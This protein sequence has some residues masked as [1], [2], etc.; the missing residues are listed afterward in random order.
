MPAWRADE[1]DGVVTRLGEY[2][3]CSVEP[4]HNTHTVMPWAE[5]KQHQQ[6][7]NDMQAQAMQNLPPHVR[8]QMM[9]SITAAQQQMQSMSPQERAQAQQMLQRQ[10]GL[11]G[12]PPPPKQIEY[13]PTTA[14]KQINGYDTQRVVKYVDGQATEELWVAKV[15]DWQRLAK[16]FEQ[17]FQH[18]DAAHRIPYEQVGGIPIKTATAEVHSITAATLTENDFLPAATSRPGPAMPMLAPKPR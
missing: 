3:E 14:R 18:Q 2:G 1:A 4:T 5:V 12:T 13:K 6:M 8:E 10:M 15:K 9:Q 7:A 11:A 17:A 16:A